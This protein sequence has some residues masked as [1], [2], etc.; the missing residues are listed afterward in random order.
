M[1]HSK[2]SKPSKR[3]EELITKLSSMPAKK[4]NKACDDLLDYIP[5][6]GKKNRV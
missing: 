5:P 2:H 4:I 3:E 1:L 6:M